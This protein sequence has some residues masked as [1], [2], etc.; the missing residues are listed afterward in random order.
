M[1][2]PLSHISTHHLQQVVEQQTISKLEHR[3]PR[4][5]ADQTLQTE[6]LRNLLEHAFDAPAFLIQLQQIDGRISVCVQP[7]GHDTDRLVAGPFQGDPP[8]ITPLRMLG[9]SQ[10]SPFV[11]NPPSLRVEAGADRPLRI[12]RKLD[13]FRVADEKMVPRFPVVCQVGH[14]AKLAVAHEQASARHQLANAGQQRGDKAN[15]VDVAIGMGVHRHGHS[16]P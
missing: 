14:Q 13:V 6:Y 5:T 1:L 10:P 3:R 7:V 16:S 12:P 4:R 15:I 2:A 11:H 8:H 9:T